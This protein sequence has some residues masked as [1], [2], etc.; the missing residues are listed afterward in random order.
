MSWILAQDFHG[1]RVALAR[2]PHTQV[3]TAYPWA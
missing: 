3:K 2:P 1:G